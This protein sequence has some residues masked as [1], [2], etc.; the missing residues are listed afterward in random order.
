MKKKNKIY[1]IAIFLFLNSINYAIGYSNSQKI[2]IDNF[3]LD[4]EY[5]ILSVYKKQ[6]EIL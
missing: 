5:Q 3:I 6:K 4:K 1:L 2:L